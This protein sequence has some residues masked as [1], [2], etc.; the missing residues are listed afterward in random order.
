MQ[1]LAQVI[2]WTHFFSIRPT[3]SREHEEVF[4][5]FGETL[6]SFAKTPR[7]VLRIEPI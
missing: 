7:S 1:I 4:R 3:V 2:Q 5:E 6:I